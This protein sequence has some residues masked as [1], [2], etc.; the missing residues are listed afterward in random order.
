VVLK[1]VY[2]SNVFEGDSMCLELSHKTIILGDDFLVMI[3][4]IYEG[5]SY[6]MMRI[7]LNT[8]FILDKF[9]RAHQQSI[10]LSSYCLVD[11]KGPMFIDF[12]FEGNSELSDL[13]K[14]Q[15]MPHEQARKPSKKLQAAK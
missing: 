11:K 5:R 2:D 10:D 3:K 9:V 13:A 1:A 6:S 4:Y 15:G 7:Q 14:L 12:I 8:N